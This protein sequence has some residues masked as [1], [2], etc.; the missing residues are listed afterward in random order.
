[1]NPLDEA[2]QLFT[3]G[4]TLLENGQ[5]L[6]AEE[7]LLKAHQ[8]VPERPSVLINLSGVQIRLEKFNEACTTAQRAI[9]LAPDTSAQAWLN[10]GLAKKALGLTSQAAECFD[11]AIHGDPAI[12]P[13]WIQKGLLACQSKQYEQGIEAFVKAIGINPDDQDANIHLATAY[14]RND[15]LPLAI[16]C[17]KKALNSTDHRALALQSLLIIYGD[18][19][20]AHDIDQLV[21]HHSEIIQTDSLCNEL[22][23][24]HYFNVDNLDQAQWHFKQATLLAEHAPTINNPLE[25][26]L[27]EP[28]IRHDIEQ[29]TLLKNR[30]LNTPASDAALRLL[31]QYH[32]SAALHSQTP[33]HDLQ[34]LQNAVQT[35]YHL[36]ET[37]FSGPALAANDYAKIEADFLNNTTKLVVI[38]NFLS[39]S[40]LHALRQYCEEAT[41]WKR[42]YAN[43]YVGSFMA[44]GF[45]SRV[46]LEIAKQLK[47]AMPNVVGPQDLRQAWGFKYDQRLSGIN[48]HADFA[49]VNINFWI[50]PDDACLDN[51]KGGLVVY[52]DL[53]PDDW[54]FEKANAD[55]EKIK[56]HLDATNAKMVRVPYRM[57]RCVLFDSTYFHTTDEFEFKQGYE[58]RR[59][60]CT[61]L[62]G[63]GLGG[64]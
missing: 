22:L 55:S 42:S 11:R 43:G 4:L 41:I 24:F 57:N 50:T 17:Y 25:L 10:M 5:F 3:E 54:S 51:T 9:D 1:M 32:P 53:P 12:A 45:C 39:E 27:S 13:A 29:L 56:Q 21:N 8:L 34:A 38:D 47:L 2:K 60:N 59:I 58:N 33:S 14:Y 64:G 49:R 26:S 7:K 52:D 30:H 62:F 20:H 23:G 18:L 36:P 37:S 31:T 61:L 28:R 44:S 6:P 35:Y 40:A 48:L 15:Q 63:K 46:V 16:E 19:K